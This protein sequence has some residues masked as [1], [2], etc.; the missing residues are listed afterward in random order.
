MDADEI[1]KWVEPNATAGPTLMQRVLATPYAVISGSPG[2]GKSRLMREAR[3]EL[4][5]NWAMPRQPMVPLTPTWRSIA[6]PV[7]SIAYWEGVWRILLLAS[8]ASFVNSRRA[9]YGREYLEFFDDVYHRLPHDLNRQ[10]VH[11]HPLSIL[12]ILASDWTNTEP[13]RRQRAVEAAIWDELEDVLRSED[14]YCA[15]SLLIMIDHLDDYF[16]NNPSVMAEAQAGLARY[17]CRLSDDPLASSTKLRILIEIRHT[18][19]NFLIRVAGTGISHH[20]AFVETKWTKEAI[21]Q[22]L[23]ASLAEASGAATIAA[24]SGSTE[25]PVPRRR[26]SEGPDEYVLRHT[27]LTPRDVEQLVVAL[28][29]QPKG[30]EGLGNERLRYVVSECAEILA[31]AMVHQVVSDLRAMSGMAAIGTRDP[32]DGGAAQE[33]L[34]IELRR[35]I[36]HLRRED[37]TWEDLQRLVDDWDEKSRPYLTDCLWAYRLI[38]RLS[39]DDAVLRIS[40]SISD[41]LGDGK[42]FMLHPILHDL[43]SLDALEEVIT[44]EYV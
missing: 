31:L 7:V 25:I 11:R 12:K 39:G 28:S 42:A 27:T 10:A 19:N 5:A 26:V 2:S 17:L 22:L 13:A 36:E 34:K 24:L 3:R 15:G 21:R 1:S 37:I 32:V 14:T 30:D 40:R 16:D 9:S 8:I 35:Q 29:A 33:R 41:R 43:C 44:L 38:G 20:R 23:D 4:G 18:T 6:L